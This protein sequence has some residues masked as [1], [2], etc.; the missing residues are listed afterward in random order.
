[1][2]TTGSQ[3]E[4]QT[5]DGT[6]GKPDK[7]TRFPAN[8]DSEYQDKFWGVFFW[9]HLLGVVGIIFWKVSQDFGRFSHPDKAIES[10]LTTGYI[11]G[12]LVALAFGIVVAIL[13]TFMVRSC[14]YGMIMATLIINALI[15]VVGA[16]LFA[17][18]PKGGGLIGAMVMGAFLVMY[19]LWV[20]CIWDKIPFTAQL[21]TTA[22][23]I[24]IQAPGT[25][26]MTLTSIIPSVLFSCISLLGLVCLKHEM[27]DHKNGMKEGED[28]SGH[29]KG[30]AGVLILLVF[31]T[32][33][34]SA[35]ISNVL[36]TAICG[37]VG[38]WYFKAADWSEA[39]SVSLRRALTKS[40]GSICFGSFIIAIV[41]TIRF[42]IEMA[43][44]AAEDNAAGLAL[45]CILDCIASFIESLVQFFNTFAF[46]YVAIYGMK[47]T[48]AGKRAWNLFME[49]GLDMIV[50]YDL[51]GSMVFLGAMLGGGLSAI[52]TWATIHFSGDMMVMHGKGWLKPKDGDLSGA[53]VGFGFLTGFM[54]VLIASTPIESG[55]TALLVCYAEEPDVLAENYPEL[56]KKLGELTGEAQAQKAQKAA[57]ENSQQQQQQTPV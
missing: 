35:V 54:L 36:H 17:M 51:S 14:A 18:H 33:W 57:A 40:F 16:A 52:F 6:A 21:I 31:S 15:L 12:A 49:S 1:M 25:L 37:V 28:H 13:W 9:L 2:V 48:E 34:T 42:I 26:C 23:D 30:M 55:V 32:Y 3:Q 45:L 56:H 44:D 43:R 24:M 50:A 20:W 22:T 29:S 39:S 11:P 10:E 8:E 19:C 4:Y 27:D 41:K 53:Y 46:A 7:R 47:F 5:F 38:R